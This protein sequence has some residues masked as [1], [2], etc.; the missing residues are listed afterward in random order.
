MRERSGSSSPRQARILDFIRAYTHEHGYPPAIREIGAAVGISSTSVVDYH[1][2]ALEKANAIRRC[3][4]VSRGITL[5]ED[6]TAALAGAHTIRVPIMG[7]IAAG[8]PLDV[9]DSVDDQ[10]NLPPDLADEGCY[11]LRV[12][13]QSMIEDHIDDGDLVVIRPQDTAPNGSIVVALVTDG[14]TERGAATLKRLYREPGRIRLQPANA[15]LD[16]IYV[17]ADSLLVQGVV[18]AIIRR[19]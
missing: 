15:A 19:Y 13:G 17:S 2:R 16:P 8:E 12:R 10:I 14:D 3:S 1:L 9:L 11:A 4:D 5:V 18:R 6:D 7:Q